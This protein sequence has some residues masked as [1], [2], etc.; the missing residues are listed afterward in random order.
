MKKANLLKLMIALIIPQIIAIMGSL[1]TTPEIGTW[2]VDLVKPSFNPPSWLFAPVWTSLFIL[3]GIAAYLVWRKGLDKKENKSA[4]LIFIFQL[5]LNLFW[6]FIFFTLHNP[7]V[8]FTEIISL[9]FAILATIIAFFQISKAA[10]YLLIPYIL[11]V[12]FAAFLN[13]N[14][15][16]LNGGKMGPVIAE[17]QTIQE[18]ENASSSIIET[19][20]E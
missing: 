7:G 14:I 1:F 17:V 18:T 13:Y 16:Q 5:S 8:A 9:W 12:T 20:I 11:W 2:Y 4:L 6:S 10:G 15:W 19:I 3:M